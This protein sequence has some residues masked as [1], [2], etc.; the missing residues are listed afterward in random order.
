[1]VNCKQASPQRHPEPRSSCLPPVAELK[2]KAEKAK[3]V[4]VT[5]ITNTRDRYSSVPASQANWDPNWKRAP[6]PPPG[7]SPR[8]STSRPPPP[9][10]RSRPDGSA[11]GAARAVPRASQSR[12]TDSDANAAPAY[13]PLPPPT[14]SASGY[15]PSHR[16]T[17]HDAVNRIDWANLTPEDK[18]EFF[19]WLDEFFSRYL[20]I[21]LGP[22]ERGSVPS[23][24][25]VQITTRPPV[26][27]CCRSAQV[28]VHHER[29]IADDQQGDATAN[30]IVYS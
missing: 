12:S 17:P 28:W 27:T 1:M 26:S 9:P 21:E 6:P 3:D 16:E 5:K 20:G 2:A 30:V 14:R 11:S 13:T 22:R 7:S 18:E 8:A 23:P 15:P 10:S 29:Y 25:P 4:G 24:V 19:G